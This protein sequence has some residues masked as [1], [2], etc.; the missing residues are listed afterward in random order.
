MTFDGVHI[1]DGDYV[2]TEPYVL[3]RLRDENQFVALDD[4]AL[5]NVFLETP[6]DTIKL[7]FAS[8]NMLFIPPE[9][10]LENVAEIQYTPTFED[11]G[12]YKLSVQGRDRGGNEYGYFYYSISFTILKEASITRVFNYPNPFT[13]STRFVFELTGSK[14]PDY[15]K[16]QIMTITGKLIREITNAELD[17][18]HIG[19]N[20]TNFAWDG[21]DSYGD[22]VGNGV[23]LYKVI[24]KIDGE[25]VELNDRPGVE[26]YF[27][28]GIG[29]MT[30]IR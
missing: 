30:I 10:L 6:T 8:N 12:L 14:I 17:D 2:S 18:I 24:A 11:E 19:R 15:F 1:I 7:N 9:D 25:N 26:Q 23:Y 22:P 20:I 29:K 4:T 3:I 27:N 21:R 28:S 5:I 16:I 13:T